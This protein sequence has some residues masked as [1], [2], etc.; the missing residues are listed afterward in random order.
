[1]GKHKRDRSRSRSSTKRSFNKEIRDLKRKL[2]KLEKERDRAK[3]DFSRFRESCS[4]NETISRGNRECRSP[5][6]SDS[7]RRRRRRSR[8]QR[9]SPSETSLNPGRDTQ[10]RREGRS[11]S[12]A[13][14]TKLPF[15]REQESRS[16]S[17]AL[18]LFTR[19]DT[20]R[21]ANSATIDF[22][23]PGGRHSSSAALVAS[24]AD[25][26]PRKEESPALILLDDA[27]IS[28]EIR[29]I[30]GPDPNQQKKSTFN[31][32]K[33]VEP[34]WTHILGFGL[35]KEECDELFKKY[36]LPINCKFLTPPRI[37]PEV[38]ANLNT[39]HSTRDQTHSQYQFRLSKALAALGISLNVILEEEENIPRASKDRILSSIAD[40][41]RLL[42]SLFNDI[43]LKR[44]QLI[45]P[46][47]NKH[48]KT[49][50]EQIPPGDFLFGPDLG[51][52]IQAIKTMEKV[53]KEIRVPQ[54]LYNRYQQNSVAFQKKKGGGAEKSHT[55]TSGQLNRRRPTYRK[56][57]VRSQRGR[58]SMP[59]KS[60]IHQKYR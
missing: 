50:V 43:S 23:G 37:N 44:R 24:S 51:D 10:G 14:S 34:I 42:C 12:K 55:A 35:P 8:S 3:R 29:L 11:S 13:T 26:S 53:G 2:D 40:S 59:Q 32:H 20:S 36:E 16:P 49:L 45:L 17:V 58:L 15:R 38:E 25:F 41:G 54:P 33:A 46:L 22:V 47:M 52:K 4:R 57:E 18:S 39:L 30:L 48:I 9:R 31:L 19:T 21:A 56:R 28:E 1:M 5:S 60:S 27:G 6:E 7:S